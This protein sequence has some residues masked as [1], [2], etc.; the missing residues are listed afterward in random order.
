MIPKKTWDNYKKVINAASKT[1]NQMT[2]I[3][4]KSLGGLDRFGEDNKT[5]R[6][7]TIE[8]KALAEY[9]KNRV[10]PTTEYT[11]TGE[12]DHQ[13]EVMLL[14]LNY[15]KGLGYLNNDGNF[16][17]EPSTDRII[18]KG[19]RYKCSGITNLS[20]A[21]DEDLLVQLILQRETVGTQKPTNGS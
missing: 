13:S 12:L 5:E 20:Q 3:W 10:W 14:N 1:F 11:E 8:L 21:A 9:N 18:H 4:L 19:V 2:I 6:F 15:L 17:F 16:I 7:E